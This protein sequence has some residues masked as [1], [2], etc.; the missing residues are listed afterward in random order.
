MEKSYNFSTI[1]FSDLQEI[2][3]IRPKRNLAKFEEWFSYP[4][5]IS[6]SEISFLDNLIERHALYLFSYQEEDLKMKFLSPILNQVNF[7]TENFH[8]WYDSSISAIIN[9]VELKGY[10]DF[11]VATGI[12]TPKKPFFFIQEFKPTQADKDVEDQLLAEMLVAIEKNKTTIMR[13]SYI[14]GR[15]WYFVI[16]EKIAENSFE[17]FVSKQFDSLELESLKQIYINLQAVKLN[18]CQD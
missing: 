17:Y 3:N 11:M 18:Y 13:G 4:Y 16:V 15:N 6:E 8:D 7:M 10:T 14:I 2:V 1:K 9:G 12:K 5:P